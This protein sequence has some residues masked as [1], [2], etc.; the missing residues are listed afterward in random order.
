MVLV[1]CSWNIGEMDCEN[2]WIDFGPREGPIVPRHFG[3]G[4]NR[5]DVGARL[6]RVRLGAVV[7]FLRPWT[8]PLPGAFV[9]NGCVPRQHR[10]RPSKV[11]LPRPNET[12]PNGPPR[13]RPTFRPYYDVVPTMDTPGARA[14]KRAFKS[15]KEASS[16]SCAS[17]AAPLGERGDF[18]E[19]LAFFRA[20]CKGLVRTGDAGACSVVAASALDAVCIRSFLAKNLAL[21]ARWRDCWVV[22]CKL[23]L[24]A[25]RTAPGRSKRPLSGAGSASTTRC[26]GTEEWRSACA[27]VGGGF[28][29]G[30]AQKA[31]RWRGRHPWR[32]S[33]NGP[34]GLDPGVQNT[35]AA[36][37][38]GPRGEHV[39]DVAELET[40]V[41]QGQAPGLERQTRR[42]HDGARIRIRISSLTTAHAAHRRVVRLGQQIGRG[43]LFDR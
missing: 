11:P 28:V 38:P 6:G 1:P 36:R 33:F 5:R 25:R 24:A 30:Q 41:M 20:N 21:S 4:S 8:M 15:R 17:R 7:H 42:R 35:A 32:E 43:R 26:L 22:A 14:S 9:P 40:G 19:A 37:F 10:D 29:R 39:R 12:P 23:S 27:C 13:A 34:T 31:A 2:V 3:D 18:R 16:R